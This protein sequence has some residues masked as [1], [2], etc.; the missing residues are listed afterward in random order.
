VGDDEICGQIEVKM[1]SDPDDH[2]A[3]LMVRTFTVED[4]AK[5]FNAAV[6]QGYVDPCDDVLD[7]DNL[8]AHGGDI[9]FQMAVLGEVP[10][11]E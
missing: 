8:D 4:L 1:W 9:V 11:K 10:Y 5:A 7:I 6:E 3:P 2:T